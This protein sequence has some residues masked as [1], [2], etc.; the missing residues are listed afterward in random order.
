MYTP[1]IRSIA[2]L[3]VKE[4]SFF[5]P[6]TP[7]KNWAKDFN[8][9]LTKQDMQMANKYME[10]SATTDVIREIQIKTTRHH[11]SPIRTAKI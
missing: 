2:S 3:G 11:Y 5:P 1:H 4:K 8:R 9:N 7:T 6:L 10:I